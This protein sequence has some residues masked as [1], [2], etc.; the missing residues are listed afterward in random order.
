MMY[1]V[2]VSGDYAYLAAGG[3]GLG[4]VDITR[5]DSTWKVGTFYV[6]DAYGVAVNGNYAYL[7]CVDSGLVVVDISDPTAPSLAGG[8]DTPDMVWDVAVAGDKAYVTSPF[9]LI[10]VDI[11]DPAAPSV[12]GS[13]GNVEWNSRIFVSGDRAYVE[14]GHVGGLAV[15]D[16][17]DPALPT[18]AGR[19][20]LT[21]AVNDLYVEGDHAYVTYDDVYVVK[22]SQTPDSGIYTAQSLVINQLEKEISAVRLSTTQ[23]D[24]IYWYA[25]ADSGAVWDAVTPDSTWQRL[26]SLGDDLI[27]RCEHV[28]LGS[29]IIPTCTSLELEW[30]HSPA[31]IDSIVDV[32]GD[33]GGWLRLN[34]ARSGFDFA[35][36]DSLPVTGYQIYRRGEET[37]AR[38]WDAD[39]GGAFG[40][41]TS[42]IKGLRLDGVEYW[43]AGRRV[44]ARASRMAGSLPPG[45]WEIVEWVAATQSDSYTVLIPSVSDSTSGGVEWS[46]YLVTTHT[47]TPSVWYVSPS[48]SGYSVDN[49]PPQLPGGLA[50]Q[51]LGE[52]DLWLHWNL[53]SENDLS[54]WAVYRGTTPEFVAD[55]V[56]R[57]GTTTDTSYVDG[58]F[59]PGEIYYYKVS[60]I[61]VHENE[62]DHALLTPDDVTGVPGGGRS[63]ANALYQNVPNPF[64]AGTQIAFSLK[65][66]GRVS[67]RIF[68]AKGRLVRELV[69][70]VREPSR[71]VEVWDGRDGRG[72]SV[73]AG[74]YFYRLEIPGWSAVKKMTL[75][76]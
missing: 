9:Q 34:F 8:L 13:G 50:A 3:C 63:Y 12:L 31:I 55:E 41:G 51:Y 33:E 27:W 36:E 59:G 57:L 21:V 19:C 1:E 67:L 73:A 56:S 17:S 48:D 20:S 47:T 26:T 44:F 46:E 70:E 18:F 60:A 37:M 25:S 42:D 23:T 16:V 29:G 22:V 45:N 68:D 61:D 24:S 39:E 74:T 35:S 54:H 15:I 7:A 58:D 11:G 30:L 65:K 6:G 66:A 76:K 5:P 40:S 28:Y 72:R 71:Y 32:P 38:M 69:D 14:D 75:V 43:S 52:T 4:V 2:A 10:V 62:S 49:L 53:S 64:G